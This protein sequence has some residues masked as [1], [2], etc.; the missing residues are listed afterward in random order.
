MA[1]TKDFSSALEEMKQKAPEIY[2]D[3]IRWYGPGDLQALSSNE[4]VFNDFAAQFN[5][6]VEKREKAEQILDNAVNDDLAAAGAAAEGPEEDAAD[7]S[8]EE[9]IGRAHV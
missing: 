1:D 6:E 9:E 5:A 7:E 8:A 3:F 2:E 4:A